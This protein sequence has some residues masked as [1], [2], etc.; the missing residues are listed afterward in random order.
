VLVDLGKKEYRMRSMFLHEGKHVDKLF[1]IEECTDYTKDKAPGHE[2]AK[3]DLVVVSG[4]NWS[5]TLTIGV[6][7]QEGGV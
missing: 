6:P 1:T 4:G 2:W 3:Y 5:P 7:A